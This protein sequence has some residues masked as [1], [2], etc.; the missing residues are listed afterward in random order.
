LAPLSWIQVD[1]TT[2]QLLRYLQR[3]PW[4]PVPALKPKWSKCYPNDG[5]TINRSDMHA[6]TSHSH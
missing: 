6:L 3:Q 5:L 4:T 2:I 1:L